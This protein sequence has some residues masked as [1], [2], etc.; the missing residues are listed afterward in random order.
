MHGESVV[1]RLL[2]QES[3]IL[4]FKALG[5]QQTDHDKFINALRQPHGMIL[6]TGPTGSGKTTTLYTALSLLNEPHRKIITVED[7]VEYQ[8]E[9]VNQIQ[10]KASI[11]LTFANALR[12]IVRQD[13]DVIMVG[14]MRD[15][16]TAEICVQSALTG[17]LVLSTLHTND[18]VGSIT[19]LMEMGVEDYLLTSTLNVVIA[20]RLVRVLCEECKTKT[21]IPSKLKKE[22]SAS[23]TIENMYVSESGCEACHYTGYKGRITII[24]MLL[25]TDE[26][27]KLILEHADASTLAAAAIQQGM[28]TM[29]QDGIQKVAQGITSLEEILRVTQDA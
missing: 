25:I 17:H 19:R 15:L 20:Q 2:N 18:S 12:S 28:R 23:Q 4:D 6:L 16:E 21:E 5:F 8:L 13:P 7:P 11:G 27:R 10:V 14:E 22:L 29:Y 1:M 26:I 24:E 3:V 9:G